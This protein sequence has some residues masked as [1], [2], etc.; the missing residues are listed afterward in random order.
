[1]PPGFAT[2]GELAMS[3]RRMIRQ[4]HTDLRDSMYHSRCLSR[5]CRSSAAV[6]LAG[7]WLT[8]CGESLSQILHCVG[9]SRSQIRKGSSR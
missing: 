6:Q 7:S 2:A 3:Q 5:R 9:V 4:M 1:M 8:R